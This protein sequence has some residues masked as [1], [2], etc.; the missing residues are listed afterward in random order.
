MSWRDRLL[1]WLIR[2][3]TGVEEVV[4]YDVDMTDCEPTARLLRLNNG[5]IVA[6]HARGP[7]VKGGDA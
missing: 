5:A 6:I 7:F 3:I 4:S 1:S 2:R